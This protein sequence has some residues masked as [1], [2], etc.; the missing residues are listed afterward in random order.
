MTL[1]VAGIDEAGYGPVVGPLCV[2]M[3]V[4]SMPAP[5]QADTPPDLW[6]LLAAG[7]CRRCRPGG[8]G[9]RRGRVP[10]AD[11][12][13]LK[14]AN[15]V[16]TTHP[17]VHLERGVLAFGRLV[18]SPGEVA[19]DDSLFRSLGA[20]MGAHPC[21]RGSATPLPL[22][23]SPSEVGVAANQLASAMQRAG[24]RALALRCEV[25]PEPEFNRQ[26]R[27]SG[28]GGTTIHTF[29]CHF[30]HAWER[31]GE[32]RDDT[33]APRALH[34]ICDRLGG[35]IQY[36]G[37]LRAAAPG[38]DVRTVE[39]TPAR[40]RYEVRQGTRR[41]RVWFL[42]EG[43]RFHLPVALASMTAK[44]VR[45]LAMRRFNTHWSGVARAQHGLEIKPTAGYSFDGRR[46]LRE[47][48]AFLTR[49]DHEQL[50]RIA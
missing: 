18:E 14:L 33:G 30:R 35:R 50:V 38:A 47:A 28:K 39:E 27:E 15:S 12:K 9:G 17:L 24:V 7:V 31:W 49:E 45:E 26:V 29:T 21:Y 48:R 20:E 22:A 19:C 36:E 8:A 1:V 2:G 44:F 32:E 46:W 16:T 23:L 13:E 11:S 34:V 3:T 5:P 10:I 25:T 6:K 42:V 43:E 40:S 4:F 37:V 41:A